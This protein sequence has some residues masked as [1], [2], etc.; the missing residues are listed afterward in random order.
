MSGDNRE[1]ANDKDQC[2]D[3][4]PPTYLGN[5][6]SP[7]FVIV[8]YYQPHWKRKK[9]MLQKDPDVSKLFKP[10]PLS[11]LYIVGIVLFQ[12]VAAYLVGASS[13][14][15]IFLVSYTFGA[16]SDHAMWVLIHDCTHNSVLPSKVG[17]LILHLV[18]NLPLIWPGTISFRYYHLMHHSNLNA[19]YGD[20]D[21]PSEIEN[22]IFGH[23]ALGKATWLLFFPLIQSVRILRYKNPRKKG[24]FDIWLVMNYIIQVAY[25][26]CVVSFLGWRSLVYL[27]LSSNFSIGLHPLG[28]R[29]I[30]E[31]YAM[32]PK[33][34]TYSYYGIANKISFNIGYHNEHH[35]FPQVPW[36]YLPLVTHLNAL[37]FSFTSVTSAHTHI[38]LCRFFQS[39]TSN[40]L[41]F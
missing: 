1:Q 6:V 33:Q 28:A 40:L 12:T 23:S 20:P 21:V 17:N 2:E 10:Y 41:E 9:L 14:M 30:A 29:W 34:E 38:F 26:Y 31:H 13:W 5:G 39:M 25:C 3:G 15:V 4:V 16:V 7:T 22:R 32:E 37:I 11:A 24:I 35:D 18:A 8:N 27:I 19:T 36:V